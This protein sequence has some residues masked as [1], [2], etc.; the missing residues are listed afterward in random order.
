[1]VDPERVEDTSEPTIVVVMEEEGAEVRDEAV[2]ED[3]EGGK[4][5]EVEEEGVSEDEEEGTGEL[6]RGKEPARVVP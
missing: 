1:L 5:E 2:I 6:T 4:R 3:A